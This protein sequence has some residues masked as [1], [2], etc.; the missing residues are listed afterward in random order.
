MK[1]F[2]NVLRGLLPHV[3]IALA[4][5]LLSFFVLDRFNRAMNFINNN[6]TKWM[7]AVFCVL[8]VIQA[9]LFIIDQRKK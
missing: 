5:V 7:I 6:I 9:V 3:L 1:R 4:I 2:L 8:S